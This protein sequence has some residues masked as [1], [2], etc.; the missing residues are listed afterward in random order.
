[1]EYNSMEYP[2]RV[3]KYSTPKN[4]L[5][6]KKKTN[7]TDLL[8]SFLEWYNLPNCFHHHHSSSNMI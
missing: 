1:M 5:E 8:L 2:H 6:V 4:S 7:V 3:P